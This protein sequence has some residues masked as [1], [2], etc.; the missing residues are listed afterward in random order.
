MTV[1]KFNLETFRTNID[2]LH[3]KTH[4]LII[5]QRHL[6]IF[7]VMERRQKVMF[8]VGMDHFGSTVPNYTYCEK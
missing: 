5:A 7:K 3:L 1:S 4:G 2:V 6:I 8:S